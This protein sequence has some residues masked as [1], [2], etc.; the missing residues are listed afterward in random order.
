[1][2]GNCIARIPVGRLTDRCCQDTAVTVSPLT[3]TDR[4]GVAAAN[5]LLHL[6]AVLTVLTSTAKRLRLSSVFSYPHV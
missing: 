1:M 6:S 5:E 4:V 3:P 2:T